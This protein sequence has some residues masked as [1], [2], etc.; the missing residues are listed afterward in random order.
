MLFHTA[1]S[2]HMGCVCVCVNPH[3]IHFGLHKVTFC[4]E[5]SHDLQRLPWH[6]HHSL[7]QPEGGLSPPSQDS[8]LHFLLAKWHSS[9]PSYSWK[10]RVSPIITSLMH[11]G[12]NLSCQRANYLIH[13]IRA[14]SYFVICM[15]NWSIAN[16]CWFCFREYKRPLFLLMVI[17]QWLLFHLPIIKIQLY[18]QA[19]I[20]YHSFLVPFSKVN[21]TMAKVWFGPNS[22]QWEDK[23]NIP[24]NCIRG[25]PPQ[26]L[27]VSG[28][29]CLS[30]RHQS[31]TVC[32]L[33]F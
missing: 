24:C 7:C 12:I 13:L 18:M 8:V 2:P 31:V 19:C 4:G 11:E 17:C 25:H 16:L 22:G 29:L 20:Y 3:L 33:A 26:W 27:W 21:V 28:V 23:L 1:I 9:L 5:A 15:L 6:S 30:T 14:R 10:K 32:L